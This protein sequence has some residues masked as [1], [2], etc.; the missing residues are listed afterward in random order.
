MRWR[1]NGCAAEAVVVA[2]L[3]C[4]AR[5]PGVAGPEELHAKKVGGIRILESFVA[6]PMRASWS[7]RSRRGGQLAPVVNCR[8][9]HTSP[10][11]RACIQPIR[12][13]LGVLGAASRSARLVLGHSRPLPR[14]RRPRRARSA[15][16]RSGS[17][18]GGALGRHR[19][20]FDCGEVVDLL[21]IQWTTS[22]PRSIGTAGAI[23][24]GATPR[25]RRPRG[26]CN[27]AAR[28][29]AWDPA[30]AVLVLQR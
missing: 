17:R 26:A 24:G 9:A 4:R 28:P 14:E 16:R 11:I 7:G 13:Q 15:P 19:G 1:S 18:R 27:S 21:V 5:R 8:A 12:E 29:R 10:R 20:Q 23:P 22:S 3:G 30:P 6:G 25:P 2:T